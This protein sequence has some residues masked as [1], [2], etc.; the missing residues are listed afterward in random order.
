MAKLLSPKELLFA[1]AYVGVAQGNASKAAELAGWTPKN[2]HQQG[3]RLLTRPHIIEWL[4]R[5]ATRAG[6]TTERALEN[7]SAIANAQP[8]KLTG[9]DILKAN[10]LIL[11]VNGKLRDTHSE[12]RMHFVIP[13][14]ALPTRQAAIDV[15]VSE[16]LPTQPHVLVSDE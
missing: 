8:S 10:E 16:V 6:A 4:Q 7:V 1:D 12:T 14:L 13:W 15:E 11:K 5:R 9:A 2:A 3:S